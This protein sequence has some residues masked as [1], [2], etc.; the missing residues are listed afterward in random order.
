MTATYHAPHFDPTVDEIATLKQLEMGQVIDLPHALKEHLSGR[1][2]ER[3]YI[4]K[5]ASGE[6]AI[7]ASGRQ[8]IRR[9]D[10]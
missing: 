4:A 7:T 2:Y 1:L 9:Q 8:L 3:G 6:L 10:N 5:N